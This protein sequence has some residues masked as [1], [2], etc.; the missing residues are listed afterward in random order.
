MRKSVVKQYISSTPFF[1]QG[2]L[3][4]PNFRPYPASKTASIAD[5]DPFLLM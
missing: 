3:E 1:D 5:S 4:N 2:K